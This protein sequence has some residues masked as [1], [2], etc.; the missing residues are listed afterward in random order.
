[1]RIL[2]QGLHAFVG[3]LGEPAHERAEGVGA[4]LSKQLAQLVFSRVAR[5][6]VERLQQLRQR[7][8]LGQATRQPLQDLLV[9]GNELAGALEND[10][11][12]PQDERDRAEIPRTQQVGDE[13][14]DDREQLGADRAVGLQL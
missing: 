5:R 8:G 13:V 12:L 7:V 14:L 3:Q 10:L 11:A 6:F 4:E 2:Y 1:G 9:L